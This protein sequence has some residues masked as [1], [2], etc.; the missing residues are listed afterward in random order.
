MFRFLKEMVDAI[1][2]GAAE[3]IA[4]SRQEAAQAAALKDQQAAQ[5]ASDVEQRL[6]MTPQPERLAAALAAPYRET[7]LGELSS[8]AADGRVP[9]FLFS[10]SLPDAEVVEWKSLLQRDFDIEDAD[11]SRAVMTA[12][13]G[14]VT[15]ATDSGELAVS[16]VRAAHVATGAA[17]VGFITAGQATDWAAPLTALAASRFDGW[18]A[19]G[20]AFLAGEAHAAGSNFLGRKVLANAVKRLLDDAASPWQSVTWPQP[21]R[22][23]PDSRLSQPLAP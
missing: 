11:S 18:P 22:S 19:F 13:V 17:G 4:E 2:E 15:P 3:G 23:L 8:A 21:G 14:G 1:R 20:Q 16:I 12:L 7:F 9:L 5:H 6:A 10:A